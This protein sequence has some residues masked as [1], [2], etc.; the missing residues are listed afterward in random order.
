MS[1]SAIPT[2]A[3]P[4]SVATSL[5]IGTFSIIVLWKWLT[6]TIMNVVVLLVKIVLWG[7]TCWIILE[8]LQVLPEYRQQLILFFQQHLLQTCRRVLEQFD[9]VS[10]FIRSRTH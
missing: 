2:A 8:S 4:L 7:I 9:F 5:I 3:D 10:D 6:D 1:A